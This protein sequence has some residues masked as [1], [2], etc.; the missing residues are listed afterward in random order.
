MT[1]LRG[2]T[3]T[4]FLMRAVIRPACS[5]SPTPIVTTRMIPTGPKFVKFRTIDVSMKRMPS[6]LSRLLTV[7]VACSTWW[8]CGLTIS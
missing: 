2:V 5:A 3:W 7:A 1:A 4:I 8:V 6:P